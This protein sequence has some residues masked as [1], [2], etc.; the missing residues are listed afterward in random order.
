MK[1]NLSIFSMLDHS[2]LR[3]I[4][5]SIFLILLVID[6]NA[7]G[8]DNPWH[9]VAFENEKEVAFYNTEVITGIATTVQNVTVALDNGIEFSH[10][11]ATV[12]FGFDPRNEGT[13]TANETVAVPKW[14]VGYDGGRLRFSEQVNGVAVYT[15]Y[16][17]LI[18]RLAGNHSD[19]PVNLLQGI[20]VLHAG[21][22][23]AKLI[24]GKNGNGYATQMGTHGLQIRPSDQTGTHGL[25]I[26]ASEGDG[27]KTYCN[28]TAGNETVSFEMS[29]VE[30]FH[31]KTNQ[32][33]VFILWSQVCGR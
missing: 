32:S 26:R 9:L 24:T 16:G 7:Q 18:V 2:I 17:A 6:S 30:S 3:I 20:Y 19:V 28:V 1:E 10:P 14:N 33:I 22:K 25:Q 12:T 15:L 4:S 29:D 8:V 21:G 31:F 13:G 5:V 23:S 27:I 11:I